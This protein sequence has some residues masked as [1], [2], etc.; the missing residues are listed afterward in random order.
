MRLANRWPAHV[1]LAIVAVA[2]ARDAPAQ[3][4]A[5]PRVTPLDAPAAAL[6]DALPR[7]DPRLHVVAGTISWYGVP[8]LV[9]RA[10]AGGAGWRAL[11]GMAGVSQTGDPELGWTTLGLGVG[12]AGVDWGAGMRV[13]ARRDRTR[14]FAWDTAPGEGGLEAGAG[15]W[16]VLGHDCTAW[17]SAPS[18]ASTGAEPPLARSLETGI[19]WRGPGL[20]LWLAHRSAPAAYGSPSLS[21]GA[22]GE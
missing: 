5:L 1:I 14:A 7:A 16:L 18:L 20:T 9:T 6:E 13:V 2:P 15:A 21:A 8:G 19:A 17:A 10:L 22:V 12:A 4:F 3:D 11:R